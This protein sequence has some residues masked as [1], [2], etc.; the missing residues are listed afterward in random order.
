MRWK[1]D[2]RGFIGI[3]YS[4]YSYA[5]PDQLTFSWATSLSSY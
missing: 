1:S 4:F 2:A 3:A 5:V